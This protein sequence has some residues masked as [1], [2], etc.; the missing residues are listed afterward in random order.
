MT[1][2]PSNAAPMSGIRFFSW[3]VCFVFDGVSGNSPRICSALSRS[4]KSQS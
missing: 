3:Y 2:S 1:L 4:I